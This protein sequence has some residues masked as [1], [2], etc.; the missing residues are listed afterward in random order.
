MVIGRRL[1]S[2]AGRE[3]KMIMKFEITLEVEDQKNAPTKSE[4]KEAL[5]QW[6]GH[7]NPYDFRDCII[8]AKIIAKR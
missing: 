6:L 5:E 8:D 2:P 1:N 3:I 4:C 7:R